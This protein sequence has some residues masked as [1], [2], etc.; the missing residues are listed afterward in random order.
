MSA[1]QRPNTLSI[2]SLDSLTAAAQLWSP[3]I[4]S[5]IKTPGGESWVNSQIGPPPSTIKIEKEGGGSG[6]C[7]GGDLAATLAS[8]TI[9]STPDILHQ[10]GISLAATGTT[11]SKPIHITLTGGSVDDDVTDQEVKVTTAS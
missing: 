7:G 9:L 11:S 2:S 3:S 4:T 1:V 5:R 6:G 8:A 10:L